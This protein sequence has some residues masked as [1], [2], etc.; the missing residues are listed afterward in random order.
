MTNVP[1]DVSAHSVAADRRTNN[2]FVPFGPIADD[3]ECSAGYIAVYHA[4]QSESRVER[5]IE[6][7]ISD[8]S[9]LK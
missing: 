4:Q 5:D 7:F 6:R 3:P 9:G 8:L 1:T 2:V